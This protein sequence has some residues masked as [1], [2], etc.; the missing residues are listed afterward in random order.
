MK[1]MKKFTSLL[2]VL[3]MTLGLTTAAFA[4]GT[5]T[6]TVTNTVAGQRYD[7]RTVFNQGYGSVLELTAG[8]GLAVD[9]G[10]LLEFK[11]AFLGSHV[12]NTPA[13]EKRV[14]LLVI[15]LR[16]LLDLA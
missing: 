15:K 16:Q 1:Y 6:I 10:Y 4:D 2:L 11:R 9:I 13:D 5:N 12:V 3:A 14:V 7:G 8:V